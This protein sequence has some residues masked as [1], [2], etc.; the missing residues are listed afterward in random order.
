MITIPPLP[1][2]KFINVGCGLD[3]VANDPT[4]ASS[5]SALR[6]AVDWQGFRRTSAYVLRTNRMRRPSFSIFCLFRPTPQAVYSCPLCPASMS[7]NGSSEFEAL[8]VR[9]LSPN[10]GHN[11]GR[12]QGRNC[13]TPF[14]VPVALRLLP[15]A[16]SARIP[17]AASCLILRPSIIFCSR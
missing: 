6:G 7:V 14:A 12:L 3:A 4:V 2:Q 5:A 16:L 11:E 17:A 15:C 1:V 13:G 8:K 10:P 9:D